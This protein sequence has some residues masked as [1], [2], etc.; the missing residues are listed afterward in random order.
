MHNQE[1]KTACAYVAE[2]QHD[3]V[4]QSRLNHV[5]GESMLVHGTSDI[6]TCYQNHAVQLKLLLLK[7]KILIDAKFYAISKMNRISYNQNSRIRFQQ[8]SHCIKRLYA[9]FWVI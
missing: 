9:I 2:R 5:S 1:L 8:G 4:S 7:L 3:E 6:L